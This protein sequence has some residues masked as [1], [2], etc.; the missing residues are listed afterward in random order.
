MPRILDNRMY[1]PIPNLPI[2]NENIWQYV[3]PTCERYIEADFGSL[4]IAKYNKNPIIRVTGINNPD[5]SVPITDEIKIPLFKFLACRKN[6]STRDKLFNKKGEAK[7]E[8]DYD[9]IKILR[10]VFW[11]NQLIGVK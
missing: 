6:A 8:D 1:Y 10:V 9:L 3:K 4:E 5:Y 2:P 11:N 7:Y